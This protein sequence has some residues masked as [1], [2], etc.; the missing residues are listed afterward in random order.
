MLLVVF[1]LTADKKP[2]GRDTDSKV[3][4]GCDDDSY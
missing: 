1:F 2:S 4:F 3:V